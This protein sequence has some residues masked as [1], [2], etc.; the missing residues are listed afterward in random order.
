MKKSLKNSDI[1][2]AFVMPV[3]TFL[4]VHVFSFVKAFVRIKLIGA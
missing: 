3:K 2:K 4:N 1:F